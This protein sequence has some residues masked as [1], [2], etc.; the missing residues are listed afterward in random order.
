MDKNACPRRAILLALLISTEKQRELQ[1]RLCSR[2]AGRMVFAGKAK[3]IG[4]TG[5]RLS[6][7]VPAAPRFLKFKHNLLQR[8]VVTSEEAK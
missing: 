8:T 1:L 4:P 5:H 6:E 7:A 2:G 3:H